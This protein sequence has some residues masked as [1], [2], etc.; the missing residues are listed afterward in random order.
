MKTPT[1]AI[2]LS[3]SFFGLACTAEVAPTDGAG[4][5]PARGLGK[6]D[7]VYGSCADKGEPLCGGP[8]A[9]GSCWCDELCSEYGDC[10]ADKAEVC[11]GEE[12]PPVPELCLG[13]NEC[14]EGELCDHSQCL[15]GCTGGFVCPAVCYGECVEDPAPPA[16]GAPEEFPDVSGEAL[17]ADPE[18][19]V[20]ELV[21]LSGSARLGFP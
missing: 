11:G 7:G 5:A 4:D 14:G 17:F 15:S 20:G 18:A 13:D 10:C 1:L 3:T 21:A 12:P 8:S 19:F 16:C 6:A 9:Y 2:L